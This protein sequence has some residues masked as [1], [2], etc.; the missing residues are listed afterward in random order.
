MKLGRPRTSLEM[1]FC[2]YSAPILLS[3]QRRHS[4]AAATDVRIRGLEMLPQLLFKGKLSAS[5]IGPNCAAWPVPVSLLI[6]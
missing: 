4:E 2:S 3:Q 6:T 5:L 1:V